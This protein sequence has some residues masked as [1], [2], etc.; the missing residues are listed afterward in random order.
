MTR[1]SVTCRPLVFGKMI[2]AEQAVKEREVDREIHIDCLG[3]DAVMPMVKPGCD[4][5]FSDAVELPADVGV[6][7]SGLE[8][9]EQD[10]RVHR[11]LAVAEDEHRDDGAAAEHDDFEKMH[12]GTS[13]PVHG[14][15]GVMDGVN[16][17]KNGTLWNARC[18]QY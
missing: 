4:D 18:S 13:H 1:D 11:A 9:D 8:I 5:E 7:E 17:H 2:G 6:D 10:V 16:P 12:S 15:S 3:I 14:L